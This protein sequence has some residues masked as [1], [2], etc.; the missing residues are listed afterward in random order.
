MTC[1]GHLL[2][3]NYD[4]CKLLKHYCFWQVITVLWSGYYT[5]LVELCTMAS[6]RLNITSVLHELWHN[7]GKR[8]CAS[9]SITYMIG[10]IWTLHILYQ[11]G[12]K[13]I[14]M[15]NFGHFKFLPL[16]LVKIVR[17][18]VEW[19]FLA[20]LNLYQSFWEKLSE[21]IWNGN[22]WLFWIFSNSFFPK[23]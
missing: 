17:K 4:W 10:P 18:N 8:D 20:I 5:L 1:T 19:L 3:I 21:K 11:N 14:G 6:I 7:Y 22:F 2:A 23:R 12:F 9:D 15:P 16:S 13:K